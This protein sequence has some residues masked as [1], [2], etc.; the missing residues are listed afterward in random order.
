MAANREEAAQPKFKAPP[1]T[2][3]VNSVGKLGPILVDSAHKTVYRFSR[4]KPGTGVTHCYGA[5]AEH[6]YPKQSGGRPAAGPGIKDPSK[7]GWIERKDGIEQATYEGWPLYMWRGERTFIA[8][9][10]GRHAFGGTWLAMRA[11]GEAVK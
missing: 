6:W 4:D 11:N 8:K 10:A 7:L 1:G 3:Q 5:C 2:I 9:G